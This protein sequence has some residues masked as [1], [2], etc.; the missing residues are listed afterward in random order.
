[1]VFSKCAVCVARPT[2]C[3]G[4]W[5]EMRT[6]GRA[7]AG[8]TLPWSPDTSG[9]ASS[10]LKAL[11][12]FTVCTVCVCVTMGFFVMDFEGQNLNAVTPICI[13]LTFSLYFLFPFRDQSEEARHAAPDLR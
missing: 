10:S 13:L 11:L 12:G 4:W 1:M 8:S 3:P 6:T 2:G 7:L 5:W 9:G